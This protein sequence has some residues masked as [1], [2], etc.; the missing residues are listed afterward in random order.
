MY[1]TPEIFR[2]PFMFV[3]L[4]AQGQKHPPTYA[5]HPCFFFI[6][7]LRDKNTLQSTPDCVH[8]PN[9]AIAACKDCLVHEFNHFLVAGGLAFCENEKN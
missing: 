1:D 4:L 2:S 5:R 3:L 9:P 6:L 7:K 8:L